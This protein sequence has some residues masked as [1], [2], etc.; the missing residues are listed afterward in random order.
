[1][2]QKGMIIT[3]VA[4]PKKISARRAFVINHTLAAKPAVNTTTRASLAGGL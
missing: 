4:V 1:M 3:H 2:L